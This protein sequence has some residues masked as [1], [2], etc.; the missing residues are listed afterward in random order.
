MVKARGAG[1][2]MLLV[3]VALALLFSF[4]ALRWYVGGTMAEVAP[5]VDEGALDVANKAAGLAPDDPLA[6]W[7]V[8]GLER[9]SLDPALLPEV[10][11]EYERAV[12]LSPN[13]YRLWMDLGVAREQAGDVAGGERALRRAVELAPSYADPRWFLG[14]LLLRAGR[15][16]EAFA[17]LRRS[18]E[19]NPQVYR[20]QIF[21]LAWQVYG[22]DA[23][24]LESAAG[25][26]G[27]A[28]RAE[29]ASYLMGRGLQDEAVRL[30]SGLSTAEKKEQRAVGESL[31]SSLAAAKRYRA[32]FDIYRDLAPD[33]PSIQPGQFQNGGFENDLKPAGT[34]PFG[35]QI[36]STPPQAQVVID[37]R[38]GRG[39]GRALRVQLNAPK[40]LAFDHVSQLLAVAPSTQYRFECYV[41]TDDLKTA[42]AP[43]FQVFDAGDGSLLAATPPLPAGKND[44]RALA[45]EFKTT[46]K[47]EA[48]VVRSGRAPCGSDPNVCP[49]FGTIWYDDFNLQPGGGGSGP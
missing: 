16:E 40:T 4:Y 23:R 49:V 12:S 8:A 17:E 38:G 34:T 26:G 21:N 2:V 10:V 27:A 32:A 31:L 1:R 41:R 14:N 3:P 15:R 30:W 9:R 29:L 5:N 39:G 36:K 43:L 6:H 7:T 18:A 13:D 45:V 35:W 24:A 46:P 37:A 20:P 47:T 44:W 33:G 48:V 19:A 22:Q 11:R 25:Q 42:G 28:T